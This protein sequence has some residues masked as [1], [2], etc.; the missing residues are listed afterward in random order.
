MMTNQMR[1]IH[2]GEIL[3]GELEEIDMTANALSIR[4]NVP[5]NRISAILNE[6]RG[7][8]ADTA[9][10][11]SRF[12]GTTPE[13]W[14]NLQMIYELRLAQGQKGTEIQKIKPIAA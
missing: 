12:F 1:P 14:L 8:T 4:L 13:F 11:L 6:N 10:R 5:P 3:R 9:L 2:P 7:I